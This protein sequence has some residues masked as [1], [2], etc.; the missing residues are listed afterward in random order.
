MGASSQAPRRRP[1]RWLV[2]IIV[3]T[4]L[5]GLS[6]DSSFTIVNES[7]YALIEINLSPVGSRSWGSNL[8]GGGMLAPGSSL[9]VDFINCDDYDV[10]VIDET[11][12]ECILGGISICF[13]DDAWVITD[14]MLNSCAF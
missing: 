8:V 7:S 5:V 10:R 14:G 2:A 11:G 6:C 4:A 13:S 3:A 1:S 12:L 9:T